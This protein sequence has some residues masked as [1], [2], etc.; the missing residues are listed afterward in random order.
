[1]AEIYRTKQRE[2][3]LRFL[4]NNSGRHLTADDVCDHLRA[5]GTAVGR[6]TVYRHL[7]R[8]VESGEVRRYKMDDA[9][10]CYQYSG[11]EEDCG[12]HHHLKCTECGR[13]FHMECDVLNTIAGHV[14]EHHGFV[15]DSERTVLYGRC[16]DC[17]ERGVGK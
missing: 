3:I 4:Q 1:M 8:M 11:G 14:R 15:L 7:E 10:A 2:I 6:A 12:T 5:G 17:N 9:G 16:A 13:L